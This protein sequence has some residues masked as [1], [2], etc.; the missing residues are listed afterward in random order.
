MNYPETMMVDNQKYVREDVAEIKIEKNDK[1][2]YYPVGTQVMIRTVTMIYVGL[3]VDVTED[4][5]V[6]T[7]AAWIPDTGRWSEFMKTGKVNEC[8]PYVQSKVVLVSKGAK[9]DLSEITGSFNEVV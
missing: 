1:H 4:E 2:G 3:L 7:K 6:L 9:L 8:E 5:F